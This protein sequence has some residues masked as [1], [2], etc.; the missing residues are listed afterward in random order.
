[1]LLSDISVKRPVFA[2]VLSLLLIAFGLVSFN[3]LSLREYPAI[4]PPIVTVQTNYRGAAANVVE[5][6][7]T[8]IIEDRIAGVEGIKFIESK[9]EDGRSSVSIEFDISRDIDN[10]AN[11][12]RD[13]VFGVLD[14][15]PDEADPPEITKVDSSD[16]VILWLNLS[17][18]RMTLPEL[19]DYAER[20]LVDRFSVLEGVARVRVGGGQR[21]A[22]RIWL[23]RVEL[24]SRGLTVS[25]VET[26]FRAENVELPA[27]SI[28]SLTRQ[29]TVR[30]SR[31]FRT[32]QEFSKLV[33]KRGADGYLI[34]LG[35][36]ARV[37]LGTE[38]DRTLFRGNGLPM[39]G[40]GIIKQSTANTIAV[41]RAAKKA[42]ERINLTLPQGMVIAQSFDSSVF[43]ERAISEVYATLFIA[44]LLV[45]IVIYLFLGNIRATIVPAVTVPVSLISTFIVIYALDYSVNLFTLL[46]LVLSIGMVVDDAIVVLEN[47]YRR[48]DELGETPLVASYRGAR[49]VGFAVIAT[50][51]VIVAVF[52]PLAFLQGDL[53]R[54]FSEFAIT[55][56]TAICFSSLVAL[57]L[58][59]MI[60]SKILK[61]TVQ[62]NKVT[63][64]INNS[65]N[66]L[67]VRYKNFVVRTLEKPKKS[68]LLFL[69]LLP[70]LGICYYFLPS[71]YTP[72][73]DRGAFYLMVNGP[74][75]ATYTATVEYMEEIEHRLMSYVDS[76]EISRLLV[77]APR[78]FGS[79]STYN[80]GIVICVLSDWGERRSAWDIMDSIRKDMADLSGVRVSTVM[81]QGVGSR[82]ARPVQFVI[83]GGT[84]EELTKYRDILLQK[85]NE[86]NPG[87]VGVDWDYKETKPQ[88]EVVIDYNRAAELGVTVGEI[89]RTLETMLGSRQVTTYIED[90][91]E[92]DVILEGERD[93]QRTPTNMENIYVKSDRS[94][95][96]IPLSNLVTIKEFGGSTTLNRFNRVR[97][98]TLDAGLADGYALGDALSYLEKLVKTNLPDHVIIDYKGQSR[99]FKYAAGSI[100]FVFLL[101]LLVVF[102]VLAAQFESFI[103]PFII[104]LTVPLAISGGMVGLLVTSGSLNLYSQIALIMLIGLAAKNGIL[105]VEFA[106]QLRDRGVPF[107]D[108]LVQ[109]SEIRLRPILMTSIT[110]IAGSVPLMITSGA[111]AETR[112]MIGIVIF[113]GVSAA[114][115]FTIWIIPLAYKLL[116]ANTGSAEAVARKLATEEAIVDEK[117]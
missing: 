23:D 99:D 18:D 56:A 105:I 30:V 37:E 67:R 45:V 38:D 8:E 6:R 46:A 86:N 47:I 12:V 7:I 92:Y 103:H 101:G 36:V 26:A 81:R 98:I 97:A 82:T 43:V 107:L 9:S 40:I 80:S 66:T 109:S 13:R 44:M 112:S 68:Y 50:T 69:L 102:L 16:D 84:Y 32:P 55:V 87:L 59:P 5:S 21:Y 91:Q 48:M 78:G 106:N 2:S 113:F 27:G 88:L 20:Y 58:C 90:G 3:R 60:A 83:G 25:D 52:V 76:G 49:E 1:M 94:E 54:L 34:R 15:L 116:A 93:T 10:A 17:S 28:E 75:G 41:A 95:K 115:I 117:I 53:G 11:D 61:P 70:L 72:R 63:K 104:M 100:I 71:E 57:S 39:I 111:G 79:V 14:D 4:D 114:A 108:A 22:M 65:F 77:R 33:L 89:G 73:E 85:I 29:F 35:D 19:T 64:T 62:E 110:T 42:V 31:T 24:A 74:E 51:L 96:L